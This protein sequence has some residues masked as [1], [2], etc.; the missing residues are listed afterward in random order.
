M[1]LDIFNVTPGTV[2]SCS[3][4]LKEGNLLAISPGM[5]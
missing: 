3:T 1:G 4:L 5:K 2:E